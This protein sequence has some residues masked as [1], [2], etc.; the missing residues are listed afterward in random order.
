MQKK[1]SPPIEEMQEIQ[2]IFYD[3]YLY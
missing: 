1:I 2:I 3:F